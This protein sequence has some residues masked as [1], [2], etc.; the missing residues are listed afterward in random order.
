MPN[1]IIEEAF[2]VGTLKIAALDS[3]KEFGESVNQILAETRK[4]YAGTKKAEFFPGYITDNYL[5][6]LDTPRFG[7]GESKGIIHESVRGADLFLLMDPVNASNLYKING[8]D[9]FTS[10]DD[11]YQ[12]VKR[13]IAASNGKASRI[14]LIM[15]FLYEGRRDIRRNFE[16]LDCSIALQELIEMGVENIITFDA[17]EPRVVNSIPIN[18]FDN[19]NTAFQFVEKVLEYD[20]ELLVNGDSL[21][22]VSPDENGMPRAVYYANVLGINMGMFYKRKDYTTTVDGLHPVIAHEFL[23]ND[24]AGKTVLIV[25]DLITSGEPIL[26]TARE[27]KKRNAKKIYMCVTYGLFSEGL[28][29]FDKAYE[30]GILDQLF[31]TN[32]TY[33]SDELVSRPY[34]TKVDLSRYVAL[35]INTLNHDTSINEIVDPVKKIHEIIKDRQ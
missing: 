24:P 18:G 1:R 34:Y 22:A 35:I 13:I 10:P 9:T 3:L 19:F 25:D 6:D 23:G 14:N 32:L 33:I 16:S 17:H 31:T 27:L 2:P 30:E 4:G 7:T 15:P 11:N 21:M 12:D 26:E 8:E 28:E 29:A 20:K 5:V